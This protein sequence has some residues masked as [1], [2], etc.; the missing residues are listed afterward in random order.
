MEFYKPHTFPT[1][2][3]T[4]KILV[5]GRVGNMG[6]VEELVLKLDFSVQLRFQLNRPGICWKTSSS[7]KFIKLKCPQNTGCPIIKFT[8]LINQFLSPLILLRDCSVLEIYVL[9]SLFKITMF[10][11]SSMFTLRDVKY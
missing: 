1:H 11:Y 10:E 4:T 8:F 5:G 2:L 6:F 3:N 7:K 9:I